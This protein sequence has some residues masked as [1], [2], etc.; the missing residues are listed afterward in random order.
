MNDQELQSLVDQATH[1]STHSG[2]VGE[3]GIFVALKGAARDAHDFV[4]ELLKKGILAA[5]V[6]KDFADKRAHLVADTHAIHWK[7][8]AMFR[9]K[10]KGPVI[11]VGGSSGKTSTK[12]LL[13]KVLSTHFK[14][15]KTE[16]SQNGLLGI[17]KTLEKI[18]GNVE[19]AIIE[20]GIDAPGEMARNVA[21]VRPT[22]SLLTSIGEEHLLLL[23]DVEGV[24]REERILIDDT[25]NRGGMGYCPMSDPYLAKLT[26]A[27]R[28]PATPQEVH[29]ALKVSAQDKHTLQNMALTAALALDLG[30]DPLKI[31]E[32]FEDSQP[33]DGRGLKWQC[34]EKLWVLRDHYNANPSSMGVALESA[35]NFAQ[36]QSLPL[37]LILGDMRELGAASQNYHKDIIQRARALKPESIL[38]VGEEM[39]TAVANPLNGESV[40]ADSNASLTPDLI[41]KFKQNGVVLVKGSRGTALEK[42]MD[43]IYGLHTTAKE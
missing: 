37:R 13:H 42:V 11:G 43:R 40:L 20:I 33:L 7:L 10:F 25:L 38:W 34:S 21:L 15:I 9:N 26:L 22:H 2:E 27:K 30:L 29:P 19:V 32:A 4:P 1:F 5:F 6:E 23:K 36:K 3:G 28:V 8:A 39:L 41:S 14:C 24:F 12:E 35:A 18:R 17:P 31:L 16:K